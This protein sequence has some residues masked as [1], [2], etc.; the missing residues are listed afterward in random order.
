MSLDMK[1]VIYGHE[2]CL[3]VKIENTHQK[4]RDC[5]KQ[6]EDHKLAWRNLT[7]TLTKL[8]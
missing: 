1:H 4:L 5:K 6:D 2:W 3:L 8:N 7:R